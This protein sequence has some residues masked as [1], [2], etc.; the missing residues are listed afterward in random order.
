[1]LFPAMAQLSGGSATA[2]PGELQRLIHFILIPTCPTRWRHG[3]TDPKTFY[4]RARGVLLF[5]VVSYSQQSLA[6]I[7]F[8]FFFFGKVEPRPLGKEEGRLK[9]GPWNWLG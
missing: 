7:F 1:M 2:S 4:C 3:E 8:F 6:G 9:K 5:T